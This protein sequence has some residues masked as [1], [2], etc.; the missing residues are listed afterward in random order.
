MGN[1]FYFNW[2]TSL[3]LWL[4]EHMGA[5]GTA[6]SSFF[7]MFGED[8][9]LVV[10]FGLIYWCFNKKMGVYIAANLC[11]AGTMNPI[12]KNMFMRR[13]PYFDNEA[14]KCLKIVEKDADMYDIVEQGFS[15]PSG[16]STQAASVYSSI[17]I[18]MKKRWVT[19]V[20]IL[21]TVLVG[22]SRFCLGVHYPTDVFC[23]WILGLVVV[24]LLPYFRRL[25]PKKEWFYLCVALLMLPG[26][27]FVRTS[28]YYTGMG[29]TLGFFAGN[30]F[31]EKFVNFE[32][33]KKPLS[34]AIRLI[35]GIAGYLILN[36]GLKMPFSSEFLGSATLLAFFV[37]TCRYAIIL[38]LL[39]G[40]YPLAFKKI[41][42]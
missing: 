26:F 34:I 20:C 5:A 30:L 21:I 7:T 42:R 36:E 15:F 19:L 24:F 33:T 28:D 23:G 6:V 9:F 13:R 14:I 40:V 25:F 22:V 12:F 37:R 35:L 16:H 32:N 10:L 18:Y 27:F 8:M 11:I 4:Q 3:I 29:I 17:A 1:T 31:E 41:A 39:V 38:F 2:E